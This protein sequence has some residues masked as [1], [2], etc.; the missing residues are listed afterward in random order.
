MEKADLENIL[1]FRESNYITRLLISTIAF[2][3]GINI[4]DKRYA[5]H[6]GA[7]ESVKDFWQ[8]IGRTGRDGNR[9]TAQM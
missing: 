8:E 2:R 9:A 3:I 6:W 1:Q 4:P 5:L 7:A